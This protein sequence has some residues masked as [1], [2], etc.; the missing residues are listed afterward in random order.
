MSVRAAESLPDQRPGVMRVTSVELPA[1]PENGV[2][3]VVAVRD[4]GPGL[5]PSEQSRLFHRFAQAN[6]QIDS[7]SGFGLGLFVSRKIVELHDGFIEVDSAR[8]RGSVFSLAIPASRAELPQAP[9]RLL[10]PPPTSSTPLISPTSPRPSSQ[11]DSAPPLPR[12]LV[13]EGAFN[14][15]GGGADP[16]DNSINARVLM[17]Q[18]QQNQFTPSVAVNGLVRGAC[19]ARRADMLQKALEA[20]QAVD[21]ASASSKPVAFECV[22]MDIVRRLLLFDEHCDHDS[23]SRHRSSRSLKIFTH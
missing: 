10:V 15:R 17:R 2:W 7:L 21:A 6:P 22:L 5:D 18:L 14:G 3:L 19:W 11:G 13:V 16:A 9:T 1:R 20:L 12:V 8:G 4:T 23:K